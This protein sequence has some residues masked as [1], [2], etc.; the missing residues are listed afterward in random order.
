VASRSEVGEGFVFL[1][2]FVAAGPALRRLPGTAA[3]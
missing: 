3:A 2:F 1:I